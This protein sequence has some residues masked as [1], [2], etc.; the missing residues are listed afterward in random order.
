VLHALLVEGLDHKARERVAELLNE[1]LV[2]DTVAD[3]QAL[4]FGGR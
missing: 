1:P 4:M 3:A 2:G